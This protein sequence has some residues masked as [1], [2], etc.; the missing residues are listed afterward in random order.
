MKARVSIVIPAYNKGPQI[1]DVLGRLL[2][3]SRFRPKSW[4]WWTHQT[5]RLCLTSK[6]LQPQTLASRCC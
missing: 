3:R 6:S 4:S 1:E 2:R 5:I